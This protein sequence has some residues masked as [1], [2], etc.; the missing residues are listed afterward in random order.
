MKR[1][2][3]PVLGCA[4][5]ASCTDKAPE[6]TVLSGK[7]SNYDF[8]KIIL[9][10]DGFEKEIMLNAD[11]SFIDTLMLAHDGG[12]TLA[13]TDIYLQ[14]G[15]DLN[16]DMDFKNPQENKFSG[17]L[18]PEN[19]YLLSKVKLSQEVLGKDKTDFYKLEEADFI[20][21]VNEY[22]TKQKELLNKTNFNVKGFKALEEK[23]IAYEADF[24]LNRYENYHSYF[25]QKEG[26]KVSEN[27]PK[28]NTTDLDNA[29]DFRFSRTY[30]SLVNEL[31]QKNNDNAYNEQF[32]QEYD[33]E[34][35]L[36][37]ILTNFK[38][39]KSDNVRNAIAKR[40]LEHYI[41]PESPLTEKVYQELMANVTD[42]TLKGKFTESY[43]KVKALAK[44]NPSPTFNFEN[45]KGGKTALADL[46]GKLVYIDVWA[47]WCGPC[48]QEIPHL[49]EVE[50]KY[51]GK[52]I[53]F[54]S[55]SVDDKRDYDKW[56]NFVTERELVGTQLFADNAWETPFVKDYVITGIPHFILL[57][58]QGNI[59]SA[60]AP[61]P[62]DPKLIELLTENGI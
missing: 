10:G 49:K 56:K 60:D 6:Y 22:S 37:V 17:S 42:E 46:K 34:K 45:H 48:L 33:E 53:E 27:F 51:H 15:K 1:F 31:F 21:K 7:V 19:N 54:V 18:A 55:I 57:D 23:T 61:R 50:K 2:I 20:A 58:T 30:R 40:F 38:K 3:I 41:S 62:S 26:F 35:Y 11:K 8:E 47:T 25:A 16:V 43:N 24:L 9:V 5:L 28:L 36:G 44:G 59:I 14:K 29:E 39:I 12:Y 52:N 4:V 13:R 32:G